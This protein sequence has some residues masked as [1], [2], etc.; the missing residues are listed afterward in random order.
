[1]SAMI[2][3][4]P[5][6]L[7]AARRI[8]V[9]G[10]G[11]MGRAITSG[12][13]HTGV[14]TPD[15]VAVSDRA[16]QVAAA[17]AAD[18]GV[19]AAPDGATACAGADVV[20]LCVKPADVAAVLDE[21]VERD[22]I[23]HS[24]LILSIAAGVR[25]ATIEQRTGG[26]VPVVRAMPNTPCRI[27]RGMTVLTRGT[28]ATEAHL[29]IGRALFATLGRVMI[30][31]ERHFDAVTAVSASGPAF[32]YVLIEAIAEGGVM[33]GLPR[34][35][36]TELAAQMA[37]GASEMVLTTELHP[38][39]LKDEVTTPAGCTIAGLLALEDGRIRSVLARAIQTTAQVAAG[40]K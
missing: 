14:L 17:L 15:R 35:V 37:L 40:L 34:H 3:P 30:L 33:C 11:T 32:V 18:A 5:Q 39:A 6:P 36:A 21:L 13:I 26:R 12:L 16:Q 7:L 1:M 29:D 8:A 24:P 20:L 4:E 9:I 19:T 28:H 22:A 10:S 31:D 23:A 27:G 38:A 2:Q 25:I